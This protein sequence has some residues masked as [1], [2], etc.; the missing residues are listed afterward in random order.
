MTWIATDLSSG[1]KP[2]GMDSLCCIAADDAAKRG[3]AGREAGLWDIYKKDK[4][5]ERK[6]AYVHYLSA[7]GDVCK[8]CVT[9]SLSILFSLLYGFTSA[10]ERA[11]TIAIHTP[12]L[13]LR[14]HSL[15][16][17]S[18]TKKKSQDARICKDDPAARSHRGCA[19][20]SRVRPERC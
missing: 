9:C 19:S 13:T 10:T 20:G 4:E 18:S 15:V 6:N 2:I 5:R 12:T 16:L 3:R 14:C 11:T 8:E 17:S 7:H 1:F